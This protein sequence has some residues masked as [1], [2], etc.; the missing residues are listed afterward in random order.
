MIQRRFDHHALERA[1]ADY[2]KR[3]LSEERFRWD[4]FWAL[5][6]DTRGAWMMEV[7]R[8]LNDTNIDTALKKIVGGYNQH[9]PLGGCRCHGHLR[10]QR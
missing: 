8:Y 9:G 1:R 4:V 10:T 2:Q 3:G 5:H 6:A 7:Y